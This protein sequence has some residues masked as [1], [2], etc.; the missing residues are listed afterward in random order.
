MLQCDC[1]ARL[2][3]VLVAIDFVEVDLDFHDNSEVAFKSQY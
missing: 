2:H 3:L 1:T